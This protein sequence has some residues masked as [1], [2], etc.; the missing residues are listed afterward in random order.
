[1]NYGDR[2]ELPMWGPKRRVVADLARFYDGT[3]EGR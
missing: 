3:I 2:I 1:V